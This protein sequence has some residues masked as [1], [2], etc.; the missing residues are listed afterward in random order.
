MF[1]CN[2]Y[3]VNMSVFFIIIYIYIRYAN[4]MFINIYE[5]DPIKNDDVLSIAHLTYIHRNVK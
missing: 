5:G 2:K 3:H 1:V 4:V